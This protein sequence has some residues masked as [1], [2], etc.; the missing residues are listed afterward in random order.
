M[1]NKVVATRATG[2]KSAMFAISI[3]FATPE[4][5]ASVFPTRTINIYHVLDLFF[6]K[7]LQ[8]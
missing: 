1:L 5:L 6:N 7:S 2:R 8:L 3:S 4:A